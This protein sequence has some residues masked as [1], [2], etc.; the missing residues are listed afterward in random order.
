MAISQTPTP[1]SYQQILADIVDSFLSQY[2]LPQLK[3]GSPLLRLMEAAAMS[4]FRS[5][6]DIFQMLRSISVDQATGQALD[7]LGA[8]EQLPRRGQTFASGPVTI[9]DTSFSKLSSKIYSGTPAPIVGSATIYV[10]DATQFPSSGSVYIGRGTTN[11]EGP[12]AYTSKTNLGTYW[13]LTLGVSSHT[14]KFH[15]LSETVIVAQGGNRVVTSGTIVQTAQGNATNAIQFSVLYSA[16]LPDGETSISN[17]A[18][19]AS[20]PGTAGNVT[21]ATINQ[22]TS[23]PFT[24]AA[25]TNPVPFT[26]AVDTES[27]D[28]YRQRIKNVIQSRTQGTALA[29]TTGVIGVTSP[30]E[31]KAVA[32]ASVVTRAGF[33]TV[34]YIDDGTGYEEVD[35]GVAF[36]TLVANAVGG[37]QYFQIESVP[38][39]AKAFVLT[40]IDSPFD[41][42]PGSILSVEISGLVYQH[43]FTATDFLSPANATAFEIASSING[44]AGLPYSART[45]NNFSQVALFAKSDTDDSIQVVPLTATQLALGDVD[46]NN[47]L[48]FPAGRVDT[49]ELYKN[50]VLLS[51]DGRRASVQTQPQSSWGT[52]T[53]PQTLIL[54]VDGTPAVT[55]T[56]TDVM[57]QAFGYPTLSTAAPLPIWVDV[58][59]AN[60]PGI[61]ASVESGAITFVSNL[62]LSARA[63]LHFSGG[64]L[65]TP[66]FG[67]G[68]TASTGANNDFTL[69]RNR[70]Q[71]YLV[72]PLV[73]GD[74]LT[75]GTPDP[76]AFVEAVPFT[77]VVL[78]TTGSLWFSVDADTSV[79]STG[80]NN[81]TSLTIATD[82]TNGITNSVRIT[83]A[84]GNPFLNVATAMGALASGQKV[85]AIFTDANFNPD[86]LGCYAVDYI[87][88][89]GDYFNV[90]HDGTVAQGP[91]TLATSGLTFVI[92]S[93]IPQNVLVAP[94][95]YTATSL[96]SAMNSG[97]A[98]ITISGGAG[99]VNAVVAGNNAHVTWG[100]SD[101]ATA[102]ALAAAMNAVTAIAAYV[103]AVAD[104][105]TIIVTATATAPADVTTTVS[106]TGIS[107]DVPTLSERLLGATALPYRTTRLRVRTNSN[108]LGGDV[109][110][111]AQNSAAATVGLPIGVS[112]NISNHAASSETAHAQAGTPNFKNGFAT[113]G[114]SRSALTVPT[115]YGIT[116][117]SLIA[118]LRGA[119]DTNA[120]GSVFFPAFA[121]NNSF[122]T[123]VHSVSGTAVVTQDSVLREWLAGDGF[124]VASPYA[125]GPHDDIGFVIDG[126]TNTQRYV[127]NTFR[128][129]VPTNSTYG[130]TNSF[131]DVDNSNQILT[132]GFGQLFDFTDFAVY[133]HARTK[134]HAESGDTTKTLVWRAN[135][136]GSGGNQYTVAYG[137]PLTASAGIAV[138]VDAYSASTINITTRLAA[139]PART[140][141]IVSDSAMVGIAATS[142][143]TS[144]YT[145]TFVL[146]FAIASGNLSRA[147][148]T[149]TAT[150]TLPSGVT[151]HGF[152]NGNQL[153]IASTDGNFP[154]G[155]KT[156]TRINATQFTYTEAGAAVS[157][158]SASTV[159]FDVAEA[160]L[161][162]STVVSGDIAVVGN[163]ATTVP[164]GDQA[165]VRISALGAQYWTG[166]LQNNAGPLTG[167]VVTWY[168]LNL[169]STL[170]FFPLVINTAAQIATAVNALQA[171]ANTTV[172]VT[173]QPALSGAGNITQASY[174]E[175]TTSGYSYSFTDG[176]NY[177]QSQVAP[178]IPSNNY[179][180]TF[181]NAITSTLGTNSGW[182]TEDV[183]LV[184]QTALN[185]AN[186]FN[187]QTVTGLS[188]VAETVNSSDGQKVQVSS[189]A[190]GSASSVQCQ[191]GKANFASAAIVGSASTVSGGTANFT[192]ATSDSVP[193]EGGMW[194]AIQNTLPQVKSCFDSTTVLNTVTPSTN[195]FVVSVKHCWDYANSGP[196][197]GSGLQFE[198]QGEFLA[199]IWTGFGNDPTLAGVSE[200]DWV[201]LDVSAS[202]ITNLTAIDSR[203][204][205]TFRVVRV[206]T[207]TT[208]FWI[209]NASAVEE[210][211]IADVQFL[212]FES[213]M[214]GDTVNI[215]LPS[216][217]WGSSIYLPNNQLYT[218]SQTFNAASPSQFKFVVNTPA[219]VLV[220]FSGSITLG[221]N[222]NLFVA[223]A[224]SAT[225]LIKQILSLVPNQSNGAFMDIKITTNAQYSDITEVNGSLM[226]TLDKL[227]FPTSL[228][229]GTDGYSEV[230]GLIGAV[231]TVA[232][233][234][235]Q[236]P[237]SLPGIVAAG[238]TVNV[239]GP[240]VK[241]IQVSLALRIKSGIVVSDIT[242]NVKSAVAAVI[243]N[244]GI[245]QSIAISDIVT[246]AGTVNGVQAVTILSPAYNAGNDLIPVQPFEKPLVISID[247]DILVSLT[248]D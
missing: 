236:D 145:C 47:A 29:L 197:T 43:V 248:G 18:V 214:P 181:K 167:T 235:P 34:L 4:D 55:Y 182:A 128:K 222:A 122:V 191:G 234:D 58:L 244:T 237:T 91:F 19:V 102:T 9:S 207:S 127:F 62:G 89:A 1:R 100:V 193:F 185:V 238:A 108:A 228:N 57:F 60:I 68:L 51:K 153:Y 186:F 112:T 230:V 94:G 163:A 138:G 226:E 24:G 99:V 104:G 105:N 162:S 175:F 204:S 97:V 217:A 80:V 223:R 147:A 28:A 48:G 189:L 187:S 98:V 44:D 26:N 54:A 111:L 22:F 200:G 3:V 216:S 168:P 139:G 17:V 173:A 165:P 224:G 124:Y 245:G 40:S 219:H 116:S 131:Y 203:N 39:V 92:G 109:G 15:N 45:A 78:A 27:D 79:I 70:G 87:H 75:I 21:A 149:V 95:T 119:Q 148:T 73:A 10:T 71:I 240:L 120:V 121:N 213:L 239:S 52:L 42:T 13:S 169:A 67:S 218:V 84:S 118:G 140:G 61:T 14:T 90:K 198:K 64:T 227:A 225:R 41:I 137:Y 194:V 171:V 170:S 141:V 69:D 81:L 156:I 142:T 93:T 11:Y 25:V 117:G 151:D 7:L 66:L 246:A 76:R 31:N 103:S 23:P 133:M 114:V 129:L 46:A 157:S 50:G 220:S 132:A 241:R 35:Q 72:E 199:V 160:T 146:G 134:S 174:E 202:T 12:L 126:N 196:V 164:A 192:I 211:G 208:T 83:A 135:D 123:P 232:Y 115:T 166:L 101:S 190:L 212:T 247:Q 37:E 206:D 158:V 177:I 210:I 2:G 205:G 159:S 32:S 110:L 176:I 136:F 179:T 161:A 59:N 233:G 77:S 36:E 155:I 107:I 63:S 20:Q 188:S 184:P 178:T 82:P 195:T 85:W 231:N 53:A 229:T 106:G 8:D 242:E 38:P 180:L 183:R 16:T 154:S 143:P 96:A 113:V 215:S 56:F 88:P 172:P 209:E 152:V 144:N 5:S 86:N 30:T 201:H 6:Q 150:V 49:M 33:P 130:L 74:R 65:L 221:S 125:I 243:N